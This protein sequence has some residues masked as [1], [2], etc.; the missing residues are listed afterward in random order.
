MTTPDDPRPSTS[1]APPAP[2]VL[3]QQLTALLNVEEIDTDLYRGRRKPDGR[4]RV[5]GGE[6]IAQAL[7]AR[8]LHAPRR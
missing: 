1:D 8:L 2:D 4:G 5:F 6:V 7:P 3:V